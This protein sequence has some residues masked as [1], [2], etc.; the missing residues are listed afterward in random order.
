MA[1]RKPLFTAHSGRK[2]A[3]IPRKLFC[4]P[5]QPL[6]GG[7]RWRYCPG[8]PFPL[9]RKASA[10]AVHPHRHGPAGH[11]LSCLA[12]QA[13][14]HNVP[15]RDPGTAARSGSVV[16]SVAHPTRVSAQ[17]VTTGVPASPSLLSASPRGTATH[18]K[19]GGKKGS[20]PSYKLLYHPSWL[21][22]LLPPPLC[23][24]PSMKVTWPHSWY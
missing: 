11:S 2:R 4:V 15:P 23:P 10:A 16:A 21:P 17:G 9:L 20:C 7:G 6:A 1:A 19:A 24:C 22:S 3:L 18:T 12:A 13:A 5:E 8:G 14:L